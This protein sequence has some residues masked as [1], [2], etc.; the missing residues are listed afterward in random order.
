VT[1]PVAGFGAPVPLT[2]RHDLEDFNSGE[3]VLDDWLRQRA[4]ANMAIAASR[5]YVVCPTG[6]QSVIGFY[7]L[8]MG[9]ILNQEATGAMRRN[10]PRQIPAVLLGRLAIDRNWQGQGLGAALL[11][12]A[13][14][15]SLRAA[16]EVS[17]RLL[18]VHAISPPAE[19]FYR[20]FGFARLPVETPTLAL[21]LVK[22][23][24][25]SERRDDF[26]KS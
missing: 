2:A 17:A 8:S 6:S 3:V 11:H 20:H 9:Q 18:V 26:P 16:G 25:A 1:D 13:V 19:A 21:D 4:L 7:A 14:Q 12:D 15:R 23:A 10:M 5:T 24:R 22:L